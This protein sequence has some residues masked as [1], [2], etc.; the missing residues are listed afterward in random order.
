VLALGALRRAVLALAAGLRA[1][2]VLALGE[3]GAVGILVAIS[4]V[5]PRRVRGK[6]T[7]SYS[8]RCLQQANTCL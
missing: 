3:V 7:C 4:Y 8:C 2:L 5:S 1:A 6:V